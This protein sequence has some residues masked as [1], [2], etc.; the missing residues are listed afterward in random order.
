MNWKAP[1]SDTMPA[2]TPPLRGGSIHE[3]SF[4]SHSITSPLASAKRCVRPSLSP[5]EPPSF[6]NVTVKP[7]TSIAIAAAAMLRNNRPTRSSKVDGSNR[8]AIN[9]FGVGSVNTTPA[10]S[11]RTLLPTAVP[12]GMSSRSRTG[13]WAIATPAT[14]SATTSTTR[15]ATCTG[16]IVSTAVAI[17]PSLAVNANCCVSNSQR[18]AKR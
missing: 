3:P 2:N 4:S 8:P 5:T 7:P 18:A 11:L 16:S 17:G 1:V 12:I 15:S 13:C 9:A 10:I 14:R 6:A